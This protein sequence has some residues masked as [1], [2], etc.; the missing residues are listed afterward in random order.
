MVS[1]GQKVVLLLQQE[2]G[3]S[4]SSIVSDNN[5]ALDVSLV[6]NALSDSLTSSQEAYMEE[7]LG[8]LTHHMDNRTAVEYGTELILNWLLEDIV[9]DILSQ[10]SDISVSKSGKDSQREFLDNPNSDPDLNISFDGAEY[11]IEL[12]ADYGGFWQRHGEIDLRDEKYPRLGEADNGMLL[13]V[14]F[15][16]GQVFTGYPVTMDSSYTSSHPYW[17][18]PAYRIDASSVSF[19][20]FS[21]LATAVKK[22]A[23][24]MA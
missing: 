2:K 15:E 22:T 9:A 19:T 1:N 11:H 17:N 4:V 21:D 13:G 7:K 14:D 3:M 8:D 5:W 6:E 23:I 10:D 12:T 24:I 20:D 16:N 18:K